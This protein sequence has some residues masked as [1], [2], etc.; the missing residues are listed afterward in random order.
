MHGLSSTPQDKVIDDLLDQ[1]AGAQF[2]TR[3]D[4]RSGYHQIR[5]AED[6]IEKTTFRTRY[7][8]YE[9]LV[10]SFGLMGAPRTFSRLGND[11]F[12]AFLDEFVILYIYDLLIYNKTLEEHMLHVK[13]VLQI[14]RENKLYANPEK[15]ELQYKILTS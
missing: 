3:I 13:K 9:W 7:D 14:P 10:M 8:N 6:D 1:S 2:F 11:P 15:C 4:L 12:R 5:V